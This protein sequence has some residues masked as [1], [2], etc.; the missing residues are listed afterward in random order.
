MRSQGQPPFFEVAK[1]GFSP[2]GAA[3]WLVGG[4]NHSAPGCAGV[5]GTVFSRFQNG[6]MSAFRQCAPDVCTDRQKRGKLTQMAGYR[7]RAARVRPVN[8]VTFP[9]DGTAARLMAIRNTALQGGEVLSRA[10]QG[11]TRRLPA[12][13]DSCGAA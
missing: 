1:S 12:A 2:T 6:W 4:S 7:R 8:H 5:P 11:Q 10:K 13:A 3:G 9:A